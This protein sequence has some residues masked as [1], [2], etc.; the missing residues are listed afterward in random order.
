MMQEED[1]IECWAF[2][3]PQDYHSKY[4]CES[5]TG[6]GHASH[7]TSTP[8]QDVNSVVDTL[9]TIRASSATD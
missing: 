3:G 2:L 4:Y 6:D 1:R 5:H 7:V 8:N 9:Q